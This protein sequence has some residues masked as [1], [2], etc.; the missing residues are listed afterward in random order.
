VKIK[1]FYAL[2]T[3]FLAASCSKNPN[4]IFNPDVES[5][6]TGGQLEILKIEFVDTAT[7]V[8]FDFYQY[9]RPENWYRFSSKSTLTG[10]SGK[11][12]KIIGSDGITLDERERTPLDSGLVAFTLTFEPLDKNEKTIDFSS[13]G[14]WKISGIKLYSAKH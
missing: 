2:L 10:G 13:D 12:Y 7:I 3:L 14:N 4:V 1:L 9:S 8:H 6:D 5:N 11:V